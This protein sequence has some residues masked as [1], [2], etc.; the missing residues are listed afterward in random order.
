MTQKRERRAFPIEF[1]REVLAKAADGEK[2][3]DLA[4]QHGLTVQTIYSWR[5]QLRDRDLDDA[6]E[7]APRVEQSGVNP[8]YVRQLEEKLRAANEKLGELYIV[9]EALKKMEQGSKKN[10]NSFI[11][12]DTSWARSKRPAK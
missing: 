7:R 11:A 10:A 4:N 6:V 9:V 12:T 3:S 5:R 8:K 2:V 1:K